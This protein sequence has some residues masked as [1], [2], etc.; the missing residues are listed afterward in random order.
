MEA[1]L[2]DLNQVPLQD[3]MSLGRRQLLVEKSSP[4]C[5]LIS[6]SAQF[7]LGGTEADNLILPLSADKTVNL[8]DLP[9]GTVGGASGTSSV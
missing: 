2:M 3:M 1:L 8:K 4:E 9:V 6:I 5:K 7:G